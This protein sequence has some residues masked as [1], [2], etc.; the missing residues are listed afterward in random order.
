M[1]FAWRIDTGEKC[2]RLCTEPLADTPGIALFETP[3]ETI[4]SFTRMRTEMIAESISYGLQDNY[5]TDS[6]QVFTYEC[7]K[8]SNYTLNDWNGGD[9]LIHYVNLS[10]EPAPC[11]SRCFYCDVN[12]DFNARLHAGYYEKI[13]D[14]IEW[15]QRN[16]MIAQDAKWQIS[17][18]EITIHPYKERIYKL[19]EKKATTFFTNCFIYDESIAA[20][21]AANPRSSINMSIDAGTPETW[22]KVKGVDNFDSV[23]ANLEKYE[24]SSDHSGQVTLKYIIFPGINDSLEDYQALVGIMESLNAKHL[25]IAC[26]LR[27][28]KNKYS[29]GNRSR[30]LLICSAAR[31][32]GLLDTRGIAAI[33]S[34]NGF[35]PEEIEAITEQ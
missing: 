13:F 29:R 35:S 12:K 3:E 19:V 6:L 21:L 22:R 7:A 27:P 20:N 8:C 25:T 18:N 24:A 33:V 14:A 31:L 4:T 17:S 9:G 1:N 15:A 23:K 28:G 34:V 32:A 11:Q 5:E 30:E 10:M 26:D 16:D 2:I